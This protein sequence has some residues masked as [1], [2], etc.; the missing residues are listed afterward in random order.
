MLTMT[1]DGGP[2]ATVD[3]SLVE[4]S[5]RRE[6]TIACDGRT[7]VL[8]ALDARAPLQIQAAGR[9]G[10]PQTG[11]PWSEVVSEHPAAIA[12]RGVAVAD[13]FVSAVRS[14]DVAAINAREIAVAAS[15][16][17]AARESIARG[18][19]MRPLADQEGTRRPELQVIHGGGRSGPA[20]SPD[21]TLIRRRNG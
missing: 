18:G 13:A 21:L 20:A 4:P 14:R 1:F 17:E 9:H 6:I 16:W 15:V 7:V 5:P 19:E 11:R 8:D 2:V 3:V 10:G 12:D